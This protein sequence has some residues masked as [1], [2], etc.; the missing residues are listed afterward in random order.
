MTTHNAGEKG[1][2]RAGKLV[3]VLALWCWAFPVQASLQP[4]E[5]N[6]LAAVTGQALLVADKLAGQGGSGH[7]FYRMM[8]N[9]EIEMNM[10]IDRLQLGCG[11]FNQ[12]R[13]GDGAGPAC[14]LDLDYVRFMGR[15]A[16]QP[17]APGAGEPVESLFKLTRPYLDVAVSNDGDATRR[18]LVGI[19]I[20]AQ[21]AD[22]MLSIGR[23]DE[24]LPGCDPNATEGNPALACHR[25][26]NRIS[27]WMEVRMEG[28][29][30]G[31]FNPFGCTP[32]PNPENQDLVAT[33]DDRVIVWGTRLNRAYATLSATDV[34]LGLSAP[35]FVSA[36]LRF[37]HNIVLDTSKPEF[38]EDDF[39]LSFQREEVAYP[40]SPGKSQ[41]FSHFANPGWWMNVPL[42][43]LTGLKIYD[44]AVDLNGLGGLPM[45]D[46][47]I[48]QRPTNNCRGNLEFC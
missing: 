38:Q 41:A 24:N 35:G 15:G 20:G 8:L 46:P 7:T 34:N 10:N 21:Q 26:I 43:E 4:M 32:D 36:S 16:G 18:E 39:F 12:G 3:G 28:E 30:Y 22:G 11:G 44:V 19:K 33:F 31:C 6:E 27:G 23:W 17:N 13:T 14:D 37:I 47:D 2:L 1:L 9:A 29:A 45:R 40:T 42:A 48:S 5:E 25:G